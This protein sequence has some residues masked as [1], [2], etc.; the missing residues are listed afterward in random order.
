M[1]LY[2]RYNIHFVLYIFYFHVFV[3]GHRYIFV[4]HFTVDKSIIFSKA[5][6]L[7]RILKVI[8]WFIFFRVQTIRR[9]L[10]TFFKVFILIKMIKSLSYVNYLFTRTTTKYSLPA[11]AHY[12][13]I[14]PLTPPLGPVDMMV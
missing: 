8:N 1:I 2:I 5:M 13:L 9:Y 3:N 6:L 14:S 4:S 11:V 7:N 10:S 12:P